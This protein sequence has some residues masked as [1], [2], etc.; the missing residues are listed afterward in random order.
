MTYLGV[1]TD[2]SF[3]DEYPKFKVK[4]KELSIRPVRGLW[5]IYWIGGGELPSEITGKFTN[6]DL[7]IVRIEDYIKNKKEEKVK[8]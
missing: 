4:E 6:K 8:K 2:P 1:K 3:K 7:A 5:E